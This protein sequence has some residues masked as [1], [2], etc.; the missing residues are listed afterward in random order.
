MGKFFGLFVIGLIQGAILFIPLA[1]LLEANYN[2]AWIYTCVILITT[3][4]IISSVTMA[5]I[6]FITNGEKFQYI[7]NFAILVSAII[8]GGFIPHIYLPELVKSIS[9]LTLHY[10]VMGSVISFSGKQNYEGLQ[11]LA[12]VILFAIFI[13]MLSYLRYTKAKE[14]QLG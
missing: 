9:P 13:L 11:S 10:W 7:G 4:F 2:I 12:T 1:Y 14:W 5:G 8:G 6:T 3:A